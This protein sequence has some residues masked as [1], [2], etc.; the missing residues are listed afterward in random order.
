MS[1]IS[2]IVAAQQQRKSSREQNAITQQQ[3]VDSLMLQ[4]AARGAPL[5]G[6]NV[7]ESAQG[8]E[9]AILPY[10]FG[11][12]EKTMGTDAANLYKA[13]AAWRG[14]P[15]AQLA[16]YQA[17][18]DS[19]AGATAANDQLA[20]DLASGKLTEDQL[21]EAA[22]SFA[23]RKGVA[24]AGRNAGLEA[25]KQ[26]LN[27]IDSI[28]AG[29]GYSGDSTGKRMFRFNARRSI[30]TQTAK[31]LAGANLENALDERS[32][33]E[34]GRSLRLSNMNLPEQR[35]QSAIT[36]KQLP[37][38]AANA[39]FT[40]AMEPF[41]FFSIGP[42]DFTAGTAPAAVPSALGDIASQMGQVNAQVG[43]GVANY[44]KNKNLQNKAWTAQMGGVNSGGGYGTAPVGT[45]YTSD[46]SF[47]PD[48]GDYSWGSEY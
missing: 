38:N 8:S 5:T 41:K 43:A 20:A 47:S 30:G 36:R 31:D 6:N 13:S 3:N 7:P 10:Y 2:G 17:L 4:L 33:K 19:Q 45:T 15:E 23:A 12:L 44:Y 35:I 48:Y 16:D 22:P 42:H 9:S 18:V 11:D 32:I 1:V 27:E 26:T 14:T 21:A 40:S 39:A 28:Q 25:I 46:Y 29:K 37:Q 34:T 24:E